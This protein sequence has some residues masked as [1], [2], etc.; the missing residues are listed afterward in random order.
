MYLETPNHQNQLTQPDSVVLQFVGDI[1]LNGSFCDPQNHVPL[2]K[3][4]SELAAALGQCDVR[5]CNWESPLWSNGGFNLQKQPRLYTNLDTA[6][7]ILPLHIDV[8]LLANNHVYDCLEEGFGNTR[9]FF[10]NN[11]MSYLGAGTSEAEAQK[12]LLLTQNGLKLGFLNYIG[13][14]TNPCIPAG[15]GVFLN[16]IDEHRL[17]T[18]VDQLAS[19]VH[20]VV[21]NLHWG[22]E[23][24]RYPSIRQRRL[25]RRAVEAGAKVVACHHSHCLQGHERWKRG[26]IFYSLGNFLFGGMDAWESKQWPKL[27][28]QTAV[29]TCVVS[30]KG[31]VRVELT[32]FFQNGCVL[33][34]DETHSRKKKQKLLNQRLG[35]T[36]AKYK[37]ARQREVLLQRLIL[38]PLRY[39]RVSGGLLKSLRRFRWQHLTAAF[40]TL[41]D[42]Q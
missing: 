4:M 8:A 42:T 2:T 9:R 11:R 17:L 28:R 6:K 29:A 19:R 33:L 35:L 31:V 13:L 25:A 40:K 23:F 12:P 15:S 32:H 37:R 30:K 24:V 16:A 34:K 39:I 3:N 20:I 14:E 36:E 18:D 5:L 27:C 22:T 1:S 7:C 41:I 21:L 26:H 10:E 38:C